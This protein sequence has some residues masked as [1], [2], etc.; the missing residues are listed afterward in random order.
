LQEV[1]HGKT[2]AMDRAARVACFHWRPIPTV[3]DYRP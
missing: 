3:P 2:A 1:M